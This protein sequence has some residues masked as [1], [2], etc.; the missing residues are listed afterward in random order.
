VLLTV[1]SN[2][3]NAEVRINGRSKGK[4][5]LN[6]TD[7]S[8]GNYQLEVIKDGY[9]GFQKKLKLTSGKNDA[10]LA[11]LSPLTGGISIST[12]PSSAIVFIDGIE[13]SKSKTPV[14]LDDIPIGKHTMEIQ[15]KGFERITREIEIKSDESTETN[16]LLVQ[17]EGKL[18]VQVR[19]WGSIYIN[20]ELKKESAD[21]KYEITLPVKQYKL[22]VTHPT[23]GKWEKTI[24]IASNNEAEIMV[25][26]NRLINLNIIAVDENGLPLTAEVIIDNE[27]TGKSTP[28][29]IITREGLHTLTVI[30]KGYVISNY[31]DEIFVDKNTK[32][33]HKIILKKI[34]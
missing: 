28:A 22:T 4:T 2:P 9:K 16:I 29:E 13:V 30:K 7:L 11:D 33:Q 20:D 18:S 34:D 17:L 14:K 3:S 27:N 32:R 23:L 12:E 24:E 26:F 5:P 15:K 8:P 10:F 25:N 31:K 19:P 6:L 1:N 21:S